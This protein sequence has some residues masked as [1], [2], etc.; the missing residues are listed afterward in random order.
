MRAEVVCSRS[1]LQPVHDL[2]ERKEEL[3][4]L[5]SMNRTRRPPAKVSKTWMRNSA[6]HYLGRY[7]PTSSQLRRVMLRRIGRSLAH[8]GGDREAA[9][10]LLEALIV[11]LSEAGYLDDVR[12]AEA[13][14]SDLHR[15]GTS[16]RGIRAKLYAKGL[17]SDLI[18]DALARLA[19]DEPDPELTAA[20]AYARR[21]RLGPFRREDLLDSARRRKE[22]GALARA[23]FPSGLVRR[24]VEATSLEELEPDSC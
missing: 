13:R 5:G 23:G 3:G 20:I 8:H 16:L 15:R 19:D 12:Y 6:L 17:A 1:L 11:Q 7:T 22:F 21:R 24:I 2:A 10:A 14:A 9:L 18:D 4:R